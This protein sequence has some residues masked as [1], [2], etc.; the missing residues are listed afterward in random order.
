MLGVL[1][2]GLYPQLRNEQ[3]AYLCHLVRVLHNTQDY[4]ALVAL[5]LQVR[6]GGRGR[7][8]A[9]RADGA[10]SE[11][12]EGRARVGRT[13]VVC[14]HALRFWRTV[15]AVTAHDG[16]RWKAQHTHTGDCCDAWLAAPTK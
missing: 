13:R 5:L 1:A 12:R 9:G 10:G 7:A 8:A 2:V 14:Q 6:P 15:H 3:V 11:L 16:C 4:L